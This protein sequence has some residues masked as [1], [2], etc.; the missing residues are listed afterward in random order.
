MRHQLLESTCND[1]GQP[2]DI[3]GIDQ[4][5]MGDGIFVDDTRKLIFCTTPKASCSNWNAFFLQTS[6][7]FVA[8]HKDRNESD[9]DVHEIRT[10][11]QHGIRRLFRFTPQERAYRIKN[12]FKVI[13]VRHPMERIISSYR[14]TIESNSPLADKLRPAILSKYR[15]GAS[16]D[17]TTIISFK[18][19]I[20][21]I[22][23]ESKAN[24]V[25]NPH[26]QMYQ[27]NCFPC[28]IKYDYVGKL[29]TADEDVK[30]LLPRVSNVS[31]TFAKPGAHG[32]STY[33]SKRPLTTTNM[34]R[35]FFFEDLSPTQLKDLLDL[36]DRD[37]KMFGYNCEDIM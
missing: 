32:P 6:P 22:V 25:L 33:T 23:D 14:C 26:W 37:C 11:K 31:Y 34:I 4:E 28:S 18:E 12:Y 1:L 19:F 21:Y 5:G 20:Q 10:M 2:P 13:L 36:L 30:C 24:Q 27:D 17:N 9:L 8:E 29:E 7:K 15:P 3:R 16:T 35:N